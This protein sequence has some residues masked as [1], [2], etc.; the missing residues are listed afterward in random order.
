MNLLPIKLIWMIR[1]IWS[2]CCKTLF[3]LSTD[4]NK[5]ERL[6]ETFFFGTIIYFKTKCL[7][8]GLTWIRLAWKKTSHVSVTRFLGEILPF[9]LE[10]RHFFYF[11]V[12]Q[13]NK[14]AKFRRFFTS[15]HFNTF[16]EFQIE[17]WC[18]SFWHFLARKLFWPLYQ[19]SGQFFSN[20][21]SH[22]LQKRSRLF[23]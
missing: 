11:F 16:L 15:A 17:L 6:T 2:R 1:C 5:L 9:G 8:I 12:K 13:P 10:I 3:S 20:V 14:M 23:D 22:C 19:K 4:Q 18:R 7:A 21:W